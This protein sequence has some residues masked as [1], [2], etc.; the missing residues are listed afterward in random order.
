MKKEL[1]LR[2]V[3][4][5]TVLTSTL[6]ERH[7]TTASSIRELVVEL[8]TRYDGFYALFVDREVESLRLNAMIYYSD[9]G[10]IPISVIDLDHPIR[11]GATITFW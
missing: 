8:D 2:Y 6:L 1:E 11:D 4:H 7:Q 3:A 10:E 5:V 9:P